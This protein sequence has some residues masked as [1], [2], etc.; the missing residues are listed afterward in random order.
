MRSEGRRRG[1][2]RTVR[3]ELWEEGQRNQKGKAGSEGC[4]ADGTRPDTRPQGTDGQQEG[5]ARQLSLYYAIVRVIITIIITII[6]SNTEIDILFNRPHSTNLDALIPKRM[7]DIYG[8]GR[9]IYRTV[10]VFV[11]TA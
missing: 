1:E 8:N 3:S 10:F 6:I 2:K 5:Q 7:R 4:T 11:E 9:I